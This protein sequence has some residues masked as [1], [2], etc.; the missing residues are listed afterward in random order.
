MKVCQS[1]TMLNQYHQNYCR[2]E[3]PGNGLKLIQIEFQVSLCEYL[4]RYYFAFNPYHF[5]TR[6]KAKSGIISLN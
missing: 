3:N 6:L 5:S 1:I 2:C 4:A